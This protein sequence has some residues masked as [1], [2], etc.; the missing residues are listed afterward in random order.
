MS[1]HSP[2]RRPA[3]LET[4]IWS[5]SGTSAEPRSDRIVVE[6]PLEIRI[7]GRAVSITMRTP[8]DDL[9]LAV[10]FLFS[11]GILRS[12]SD[13]VRVESVEEN[14]VDIEL[15]PGTN[16]AALARLERHFTTTSSCGVCGKTSL[17]ALRPERAGSRPD[18]TKIAA[19]TL[20]GLPSKLL[21]AQQAFAGT[22]GLHAA[23]LFDGAG[24]L[25]LVRED[26]G[27]HNAVDKLVG[28]ELL[29]GHAALAGRILFLSGRA[30]F[31][32]VQKAYMAHVPAVAAIGAPSSLAIDLAREAGI[33]LA[34]FVRE[35]RFN[36]Y[37]GRERLEVTVPTDAEP[38]A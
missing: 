31:E 15:A 24:D 23:A 26:V 37:S 11:E 18:P 30:G 10:G 28:A 38:R 3:T 32:L 19:S 33:L 2:A 8:G 4:D 25:E 16:A 7:G 13:L 20:R 1:I 5:F 22:G 12:A 17:D 9:E 29:A 35:D 34:G 21:A 14:A 6:E 36:V 27:R